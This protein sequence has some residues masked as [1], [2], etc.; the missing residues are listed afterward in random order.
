MLTV[1]LL[2]HEVGSLAV[3]LASSLATANAR[4]VLIAFVMHTAVV[5]RTCVNCICTLRKYAGA[6]GAM[7]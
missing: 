5:Q 3:A 4:P 6:G 2:E 1:V 7:T